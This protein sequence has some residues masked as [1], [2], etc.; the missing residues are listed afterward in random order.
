MLP[1]NSMLEISLQEVERYLYYEHQPMIVLDSEERIVF[2]CSNFVK[3]TGQSRKELT[4]RSVAGYIRFHEPLVSLYNRFFQIG[5]SS[6]QIPPL[7]VLQGPS[8]R[9][10]KNYIVLG[11]Q[12]QSE[13]HFLLILRGA[14]Y[15]VLQRFA[16]TF[17]CEM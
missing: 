8:P 16:G 13:P 14:E 3:W 9:I 7:E 6:G 1:M 2:C 11:F 4:G 10:V 17:F 15:N 12:I 5:E